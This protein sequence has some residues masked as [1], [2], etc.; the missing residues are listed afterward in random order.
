[1]TRRCRVVKWSIAAAV[2]ICAFAI[3]QGGMAEGQTLIHGTVVN[4]DGQPQAQCRVEFRTAPGSE[5][6]HVVYT[7]S[8]GQ[9]A[10]T[11][12]QYTTYNV[13]VRQGS[14]TYEFDKVVVEP[15]GITPTPLVVD[16]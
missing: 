7:D 15:S 3:L 1:V 4:R 11:N 13:I 2:A 8:S 12:P 5:P 10:L 16:W 14:R 6:E 9:F